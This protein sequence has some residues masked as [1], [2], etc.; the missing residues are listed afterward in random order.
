MKENSPPGTNVGKPVTAGD[1]GDVLTYTISGGTN[2][3]LYVIDRATGQITVGPRT[4]LDREAADFVSGTHEVMVMAADPYGDPNVD[5]EV[6][7]NSDVVTVTITVDN[8]NEA[9]MITGGHTKDSKAEDFDSD[10]DVEGRQLVVA[11]YVAVD[12]DE[13]DTDET[14][15]WSLTGPDAADFKIEKDTETEDAIDAELSFKKA[16]NF[17]MPTDANMDNMYMVTVVTT[18]AKKL[19]AMRDVVITVENT[20]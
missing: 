7:E 8:V 2:A 5:G 18:D 1:A 17:E 16:P 20:G 13:A 14:I 9:P 4:M 6:S 3:G 11:T 10:V 15:D 12:D 19:T